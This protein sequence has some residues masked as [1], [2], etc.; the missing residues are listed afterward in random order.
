[1]GETPQPRHRYR[2]KTLGNRRANC[3]IRPFT[4]YTRTTRPNQRRPR[5][6]AYT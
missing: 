2:T 5:T 4:Y 3:E 1:M 6:Q